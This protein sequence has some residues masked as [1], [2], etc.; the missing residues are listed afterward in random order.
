MSITITMVLM[1]GLM[2]DIVIVSVSDH[3]FS[4]L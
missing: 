3:Q 1:Y 4:S 2:Y